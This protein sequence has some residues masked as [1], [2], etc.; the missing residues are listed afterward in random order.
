MSSKKDLVRRRR[1]ANGA[2]T[3][4]GTSAR[5]HGAKAA[6][7]AEPEPPE[8]PAVAAPVTSENERGDGSGKDCAFRSLRDAVCATA[9]PLARSTV[10]P[11]APPDTSRT[12]DRMTTFDTTRVRTIVLDTL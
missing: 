6:T 10:V 7:P 2:R 8:L 1:R 5:P 9:R 11:T 4:S 3:S 12:T